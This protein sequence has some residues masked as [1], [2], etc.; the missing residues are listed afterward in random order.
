MHS[1][2]FNA[3]FLL[4]IFMM[5]SN[6][7]GAPTFPWPPNWVQPQDQLQNQPQNQPARPLYCDEPGCDRVYE[8]VESKN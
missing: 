1:L 2:T 8:I 3:V 7:I 6:V 4:F 5:V